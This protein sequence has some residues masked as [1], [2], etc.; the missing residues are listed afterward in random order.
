M[1]RLCQPYTRQT[2]MVPGAGT[3]CCVYCAFL[4]YTHVTLQ[5]FATVYSEL[6]TDP[7][8]VVSLLSE[9]EVHR[10][11]LKQVAG[12]ARRRQRPKGSLRRSL[13]GIPNR[14][15]AACRG[16]L[17]LHLEEIV[18]DERVDLLQLRHHTP[19]HVHL[20]AARFVDCSAT[21]S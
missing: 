20:G 17:V 7:I 2:L 14:H 13:R 19:H 8:S 15:A 1:L 18:L 21:P 9:C 12:V 16:Y 4:T 5:G 10:L 6:G 11:Q 3:I